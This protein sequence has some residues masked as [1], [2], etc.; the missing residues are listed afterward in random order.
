MSKREPSAAARALAQMIGGHR[1]R[2]LAERHRWTEEI[3]SDWNRRL[4]ATETED[5]LAIDDFAAQ[6]RG[7]P[8]GEDALERIAVALAENDGEIWGT[9][10]NEV[11]SQAEGDCC[12]ETYR[13]EARA[14]LAAMPP[15]PEREALRIAFNLYDLAARE[16][17]ER[18]VIGGLA[19]QV[20]ALLGENEK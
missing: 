4:E 10:Q 18:A 13:R 1:A 6:S 8:A 3:K 19:Q 9:L 20:R 17:A 11:G 7:V 14:A 16:G 15:P 12:R 5:A 2:F